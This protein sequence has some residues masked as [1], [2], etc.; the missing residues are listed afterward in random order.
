MRCTYVAATGRE[1]PPNGAGAVVSV[2]EGAVVAVG[3][4]KPTDG[5]GVGLGVSLEAGVGTAEKE[6]DAGGERER[7][8]LRE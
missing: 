6:N 8:R 7:G 3:R 1:N 5:L 4:E 2:A